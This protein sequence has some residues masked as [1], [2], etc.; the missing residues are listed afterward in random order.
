MYVYDF[1]PIQVS[2]FMKYADGATY[3]CF[4]SSGILITWE[5]RVYK[6][7]EGDDDNG[8]EST[9]DGEAVRM[10]PRLTVLQGYHTL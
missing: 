6:I 4:N 7:T 1:L 10:N 8:N 2:D 3:C 5:W 9:T